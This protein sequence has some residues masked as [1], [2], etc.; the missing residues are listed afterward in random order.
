M[1]KISIYLAILL[2]FISSSRSSAQDYNFQDTMNRQQIEQ[3]LSRSLDVWFDH[4]YDPV[5]GNDTILRDVIR[6]CANT[7]AR[8]IAH[9]VALWGEE[10]DQISNGYFDH[11]DD[12]VHRIDSSYAAAS[13]VKPIIEAEIFE[14][15]SAQVDS[16]EMNDETAAAFGITKRRFRYEDMVYANH[17]LYN[18]WGYHLDPVTHDTIWYGSAPDISRIETR[19]FFYF[20]ATEYIKRGVE[21]LH[22]GQ[23]NLEDRTGT[24]AQNHDSTW[25]LLQMIR[26]Y[27]A[28]KTEAWC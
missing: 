7:N 25:S 16:L 19:M 26:S 13:L 17:D 5:A 15:V 28:H 4:L 24:E 2:L 20:L 11:L 22:M 1:N 3:Y 8:Y 12:I 9:T 10:Y 21:A 18:M 6:M 23:I 14:I 27:A